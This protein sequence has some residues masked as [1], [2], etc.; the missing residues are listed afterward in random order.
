MLRLPS[1]HDVQIPTAHEALRVKAYL[2]VRRNQVR[3]YLD[4]AAMSDWLGLRVA[5]GVLADIDSFYVD[6]SGQDE[7]VVSEL[8][9][10]LANPNP[11][12]SAVLTGLSDDKGLADRWQHWDEVAR[13]CRELGQLILGGSG[14]H[15]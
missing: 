10:R 13:V 6:R 14:G 7:S 4:V 2:V 8:V 9:I 12:D 1:G 11:H 15:V 3:D 5:A